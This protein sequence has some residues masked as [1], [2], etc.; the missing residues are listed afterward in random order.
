MG[1]PTIVA[2][3]GGGFCPLLDDFVLSLAVYGGRELREVVSS[4]AD[5]R[6]FRVGA[7]GEE[8]IEARYLA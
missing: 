1:D 4:R 7:A 6:A 5:G 8:A 3:G 2:P